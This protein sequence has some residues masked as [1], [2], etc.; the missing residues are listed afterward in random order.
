LKLY[1]RLLI[2]QTN[3]FGLVSLQVTEM[4]PP[5]SRIEG[6]VMGK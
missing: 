4:T 1:L 5:T 2:G 6:Q 3:I